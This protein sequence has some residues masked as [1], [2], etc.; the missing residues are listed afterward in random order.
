MS[1]SL[2]IPCTHKR[3][4]EKAMLITDHRTGEDVWLPLSQVDKVTRN[5][6][7]T[8]DVTISR[9]IAAEKGLL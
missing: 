6:D 1:D 8:G 3:E 9:W 2:T 5:P 4:T 7:G